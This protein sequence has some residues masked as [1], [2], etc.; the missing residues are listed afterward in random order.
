M[1][2]TDAMWCA[3]FPP[4]TAIACAPSTSANSPDVGPFNSNPR[5]LQAA[6]V[7]VCC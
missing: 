6:G 1:S 3:A 2:M 7:F 5:P 4:R